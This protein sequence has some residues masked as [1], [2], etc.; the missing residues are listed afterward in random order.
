MKTCVNVAYSMWFEIGAAMIMTWPY[1]AGLVRIFDDSSKPPIGLETPI[2]ELDDTSQIAPLFFASFLIWHYITTLI[3]GMVIFV[4][5]R[6]IASFC[7]SDYEKKS[8]R[9]IAIGLLAS[10]Q[11]GAIFFASL[12]FFYFINLR[13]AVFIGSLF[14]AFVIILFIFLY[15]YNTTLQ[16]KLDFGSANF[17]NSNF[18]PLASKFQAAENA[19]SLKLALNVVSLIF[20][21][22]IL[23]IIM[24]IINAFHL[25]SKDVESLAISVFYAILTLNPL[26]FVPT[27]MM[28]IPEWRSAFLKTIPL[29]RHRVNPATSRVVAFRRM[30]Q[31]SELY[32]VQLRE[33]WG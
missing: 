22:T 19:R 16:A 9:F 33:T 8:R 3:G 14:V 18:Y 6:T 2:S 29:L 5:E 4:V 26:F 21:F 12:T 7:F 25:F 20:G 24:V 27:A 30:S 15:F 13:E 28:S 32:F 1:E 31:E 10:S 11:I 23:A 17:K